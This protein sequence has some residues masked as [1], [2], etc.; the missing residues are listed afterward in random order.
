MNIADFPLPEC[1]RC[2]GTGKRGAYDCSHCNGNGQ[3]P[4]SSDDVRMLFSVLL[5]VANGKEPAK[6]AAD[7]LE[8]HGVKLGRCDCCDKLAP[9]EMMGRV[10]APDLQDGLVCDACRSRS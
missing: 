7:A 5:D 4:V 9:R 10:R 3:A 1:G 2:E 6:L 8:Q